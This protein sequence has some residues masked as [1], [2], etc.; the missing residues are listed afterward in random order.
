M[1]IAEKLT[2]IAENEQKVYDA[3][4]KA[5]YDEF[6][7]NF[8]PGK[9][10][11]PD[12][13]FGSFR[14]ARWT[15]FTFNP[16]Y[17]LYASTF[18]GAMHSNTNVTRVPVEIDWTALTEASD[19]QQAFYACSSLVHIPK[20]KVAETTMYN[21]NTFQACSALEELIIEGT[22]G[23]QNFDVHWSTKLTRDSLLSII[24]ALADYK[25]GT[26]GTTYTVTL[27]PTNLA[28][29]TEAEKAIATQKGWTLA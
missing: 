11:E 22:I 28:K 15:D 14:S 3:G 9:G 21:A 10:I 29:L 27:G 19:T 4:K 23:Q 26:S 24:S 20:L 13:Y 1:S 7:D 6:W 8:Q 25:D 17:R 5:Q 16:K 18:M 2:T 12:A